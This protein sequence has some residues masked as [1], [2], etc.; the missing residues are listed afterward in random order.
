MGGSISFDVGNEGCG[1]MDWTSQIITNTPW[2]RIISGFIGVD[3]GKINCS[4]DENNMEPIRTA[5]IRI[6][7]YSGS[8][9]VS[10]QQGG[11]GI[12]DYPFICKVKVYP[13]PTAGIITVEIDN[14]GLIKSKYVVVDLIGRFQLTGT[15]NH[16]VSQ[17]DLSQLSQGVYFLKVSNSLGGYSLTKV[18][19]D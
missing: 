11:T 5:T 14:T 1:Y 16:N 4:I 7:T 19:R 15:I 2:I 12:S 6:N 10:V 8:K 3:S 18:L 13:N 9:D 17:L